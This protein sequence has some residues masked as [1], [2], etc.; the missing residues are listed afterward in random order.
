MLRTLRPRDAAELAEVFQRDFPVESALYEKDSGRLER[1]VRQLFRWDRRLLLSLAALVGRP[2]VRFLV[3]ESGGHVVG[4][5]AVTFPARRTGFLG[6]VAVHP[7]FRRRGLARRLVLEA[8]R[9]VRRSGRPFAALEVLDDNAPAVALYR[10]LGY[11]PLRAMRHLV[12]RST[13]VDGTEAPL[14]RALA[15][16]DLGP[17][18]DLAN[19]ALPAEFR[20]LL[21]V[22]RG[23]FHAGPVVMA[24]LDSSTEA[25]VVDPGGGPLA[26]LR[27]TVSGASPA[28]H[29]S[30]PVLSPQ[31]DDPTA[32]RLIRQGVRWL[33][34]RGAARAVVEVGADDVRGGALLAA[35]GFEV[36]FASTVMRAELDA[37]T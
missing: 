35:E 4:T 9:T 28:G 21:P 30:A 2:I 31:V 36:A 13:A 6:A 18:A 11:H 20:E 34:S 14:G 7:A 19:A 33:H 29:L 5:T 12:R 15:R 8:H 22:G 3:V 27:A 32:R 24:L 26:F 10:S 37:A 25:W 1:V 16:A 23:A 17:L